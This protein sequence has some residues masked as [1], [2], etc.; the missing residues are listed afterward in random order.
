MPSPSQTTPPGPTGVTASASTG[1]TA[2]A[3]G[4]TAGVSSSGSSAP[5]SAATSS[6][7]GGLPL[8]CR[9]RGGT[10]GTQATGSTSRETSN[11]GGASSGPCVQVSRWATSYAPTHGVPRLAGASPS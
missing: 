2:A 5:A 9:G 6:S 1:S 11:P 3:S 8:S 4:T 7:F 10:G